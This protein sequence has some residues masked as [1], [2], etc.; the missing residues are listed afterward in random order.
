MG[1]NNLVIVAAGDDS[2]HLEWFFEERSFDLWVIYFG[3]DSDTRAKFE[4]SCDRFFEE[5]GLKYEIL[6]RV[7]IGLPEDHLMT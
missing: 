4:R 3:D 1:R 6:R 7:L 5:K 2:L